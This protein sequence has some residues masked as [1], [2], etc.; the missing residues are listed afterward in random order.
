MLFP[1]RSLSGLLIYSVSAYC[2]FPFSFL[3][4]L[5]DVYVL[6][7][8]QACCLYVC[9]FAFVLLPNRF[10]KLL[11]PSGTI[12]CSG[13]SRMY[14]HSS[15]VLSLLIMGRVLILD[16]FWRSFL[17]LTHIMCHES[18]CSMIISNTLN[19]YKIL[20]MLCGPRV[21]KL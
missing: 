2:F 21:L 6:Y 3:C 10:V 20:D 8:C 14:G 18:V 12:L 16:C 15:S 5:C 13:C 11:C 19:H 4:V 9:M 1:F 17:T 7:V